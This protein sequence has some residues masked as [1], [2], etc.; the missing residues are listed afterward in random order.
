MTLTERLYR[1]VGRH[2]VTLSCLQHSPVLAK[3]KLLIF[4]GFLVDVDDVWF[5]VT[6]G[7]ILADIRRALASGSTFDVWRISDSTAGNRFNGMAIPYDFDPARWIVVSDPDR[8]LDYAAVAISD[9]YRSLLAAGG[10]L[11]IGSDAWGTFVD[12]SDGWAL[13]G[14]PAESI[15]YDD[16]TIIRAK[17]V[18][19]PLKAASTPSGAGAKSE[20]QFYAS[21]ADDPTAFVDD[22]DGMSGGPIFSLRKVDGTWKYAV[23]GVQSSWYK[24]SSV[25]AACPFSSFGEALTDVVAEAKRIYA[26]SQVNGAS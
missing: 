8:G 6:A 2:F 11:P 10:A 26:S 12:E 16:E 5:Y 14:I 20:N 13:V 1:T 21:F 25:L 17:V 3:S 23:I 18:V 22:I 19:A 24:E 9:L 4:S 7:H 15:D